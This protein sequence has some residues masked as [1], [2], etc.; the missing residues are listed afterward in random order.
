MRCLHVLLIAPVFLSLGV[1]SWAGTLRIAL[2][3]G[4]K[5]T[6][7]KQIEDAPIILFGRF[8]SPRKEGPDMVT[9]L[10]VHDVIKWH[11]AIKD[12][13][14]F[15]LPR[16]IPLDKSGK[17]KMFLVL[18]D[19]YKDK[20]DAYKG[21]ET[22][23]RM[24]PYV[25]AIMK[26]DSKKPVEM[27]R[28]YFNYLQDP[29]DAVRSDALLEFYQPSTADF[30]KAVRQLPAVQ[31]RTWLRDPKTDASSFHNYA[32]FL[33]YCG[34]PKDAD[35]LAK[36]LEEEKAGDKKYQKMPGMLI[37][38]LSLKPETYAPKFRAVAKDENQAFLYRY[39][40]LKSAEFVHEH[41]AD[42]LKKV[43]T[44]AMT[45]DHLDMPDMCDLAMEQLRK[46]KRWEYTKQI[47][48]KFGMK[49]YDTPHIRKSI[50]R[51]ALQSPRPE[52]VAF[53][54]EM[55]KKEKE[56]VDDTKELLELESPPKA[57]PK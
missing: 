16:D 1:P 19:V 20:L 56:W 39:Q 7:R 48:G 42:L 25:R 34:E 47:L 4:P 55:R 43:D 51:F 40:A 50:L 27:L 15:T 18:A 52:A 49:P 35:E 5:V 13:K 32:L 29:N 36:M 9:D 24:V 6:I 45:A 38:I 2:R 8:E 26:L 37:A 30:D 44:I 33:S 14:V 54:A 23:A 57:A 10:I 17:P 22:D 31:L 53:V 3:H 41:R 12:R 28:F 11:P 21:I 46:W